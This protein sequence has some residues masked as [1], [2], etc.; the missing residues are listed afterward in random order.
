M[1]DTTDGR[2]RQER[3]ADDLRAKIEGGAYQ[4]GDKLPGIPD[5]AASYDVSL[6][7]VRHALTKLK[8]EGL[9]VSQ[10]GRGNFVREHVPVRRYGISRYSRS[11]WGGA[12]PQPLLIA[13]GGRQGRAVGQDTEQEMVPAPRFVAERLE[14]V[15]E[16]D[17]VHI[18]RRVT[19]V[20]GVINQ[21]ADSYFSRALGERAPAVVAGEGP[22]GHIARINDVSPVTDVQEE[23]FARMP[24]GPE[25]SRLQIPEGTP[26]V[27]VIRTYH[28]EIGILDVTRFV[29]RADMA[30]FD[31]K[32]PIPD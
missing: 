6:V 23:L 24:T 1:S 15:E 10:Q 28:T 21:S 20:D 31:Y 32:F 17:L 19:T 11:V 14:G 12:N 8:A 2:S 9:I 5:L 18:R 25:S 4:Q 7:T 27:E 13:E 16:G 22:G 26:V 29:I 30:A 3:I